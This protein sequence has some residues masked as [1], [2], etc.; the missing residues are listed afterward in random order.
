MEKGDKHNGFAIALAWPETQCKQTGAWYDPLMTL[1][2]INKNGYYHVGHSAVVLVDDETQTCQYFD[3]GRYHS[4]HGHGRIRN[5]ET[6]HDLFLKTK[7]RFSDDSSKIMN[8]EKILTELYLNPSTH[9]AGFI[10]GITTRINFD[11]AFSFAKKMQAR[12]FLPYGVFVLKGSN[13]SRFVNRVLYAGKPTFFERLKLQIPLTVS[14]S[15]SWNLLALSGT[16]VSI[17][18]VHKE[19]KIKDYVLKP[20]HRVAMAS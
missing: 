13:C 4:P 10:K 6:D 9:G 3:F 14:P 15:P 2:G 16:I 1:L 17:G 12:I 18:Q 20:S 7:A 8:L 19:V 11:E 5:V